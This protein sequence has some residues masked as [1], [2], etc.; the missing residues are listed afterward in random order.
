VLFQEPDHHLPQRRVIIND[1]DV[2][3]ICEH[4]LSFVSV[5]NWLQPSSGWPACSI[6]MRMRR[7][8]A[9]IGDALSSDQAFIFANGLESF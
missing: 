8:Y 3:N 4:N 2:A 1:N 5:V 7:V 6:P 9:L